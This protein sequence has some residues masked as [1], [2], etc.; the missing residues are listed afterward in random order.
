MRFIL[1]IDGAVGVGNYAPVYGL[2]G[3]IPEIVDS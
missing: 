1:K 3:C 2:P